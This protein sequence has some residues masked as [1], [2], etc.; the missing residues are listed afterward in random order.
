[1]FARQLQHSNFGLSKTVDL[2]YEKAVKKVRSAL[3][4]E[5][6]GVLCEIDLK[7]KLKRK[8]GYR[9]PEIRDSWRV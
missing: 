3:K 6:F 9:F 7:E 4:D 8:T 2:S 1:M 5:G